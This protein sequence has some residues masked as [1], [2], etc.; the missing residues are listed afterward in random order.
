MEIDDK[1]D[2]TF[3][4]QKF[5][6]SGA[7]LTLQGNNLTACSQRAGG[8]HIDE[9]TR[10]V[11]VTRWSISSLILIWSSL[12]DSRGDPP[13]DCKQALRQHLRN[14]VTLSA[15]KFQT[16]VTRMDILKSD[17]HLHL[18]YMMGLL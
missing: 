10:L 1:T 7:W 4:K 2:S 18:K 17:C 16:I 12:H 14:S 5:S 15:V 8:A 13:S 11:G 9:A 3:Y 6:D